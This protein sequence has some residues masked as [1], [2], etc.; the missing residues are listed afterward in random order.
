MAARTCQLEQ[1]RF[2]QGFGGD[3][4]VI[5]VRSCGALPRSGMHLYGRMEQNYANHL[6]E[7]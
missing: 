1:A 5:I 4:D 2:Q 6:S 3:A 7:E